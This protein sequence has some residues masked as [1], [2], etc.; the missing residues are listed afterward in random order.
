MKEIRFEK[1]A[2]ILICAVLGGGIVFFAFRFILPVLL[3]F[4]FAF[5][6]SLAV[7]PLADRI[8]RAWRIPRKPAAAVLFLLFLALFGGLTGLGVAALLREARDLVDRAAAESVTWSG[9]V[10]D[11]LAGLEERFSG[12]ALLFGGSGTNLRERFYELVNGFLSSV[13]ASLPN[14]AAG[15]L[16]SLPSLLLGSVI[17]VIA[18]FYFCVDREKIGAA[19]RSCLPERWRARLPDWQSRSRKISWRYLRAYLLLLGLTF[20]ELL[21][22]F[23]LL[24]VPYALLLS[25]VIA[26]VDLLPVLGVG[27]VLVP[28]AIVVLFQKN[29]Y[30]GFG[31]LILYG[32]VVVLRQIVEPRLVGHS[33]GLHPLVTLFASFA[34]WK[35]FGVIG[36]M[37][38][39]VVAVLIRFLI[40]EFLPFGEGEAAPDNKFP[41]KG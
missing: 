31:L 10:E 35:L 22:G 3:P 16:S 21:V 13:S 6:V 1:W 40:G 38:G 36:M 2:A 25:L 30:L 12:L 27:T 34:G 29:F 33:L 32:A 23:W 20:L 11:F 4:A 28:W 8:A 5:A 19:F 26:F 14:Y 15:V 37:A 7:N 41:E 24:R 17:T 39:P 18:G 9:Q